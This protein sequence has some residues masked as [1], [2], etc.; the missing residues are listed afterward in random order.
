MWTWSSSKREVNGA[1][2][3]GDPLSPT[4]SPSHHDHRPDDTTRGRRLVEQWRCVLRDSAGAGV[5]IAWSDFG[6]DAARQALAQQV[7]D[8]HSERSGERGGRGDSGD[9][10]TFLAG[11]VLVKIEKLPAG[12]KSG[13]MS[14]AL[15]ALPFDVAALS[16]LKVLRF[17]GDGLLSDAVL[18]A[19]LKCSTL[20]EV[21][22]PG[23]KVTTGRLMDLL[24]AAE[25]L[26]AGANPI[27]GVPASQLCLAVLSA[28]RLR[29]NAIETVPPEVLAQLPALTEL[30]LSENKLSEAPRLLFEHCPALEM[31]NLERNPGLSVR[32]LDF[33]ACQLKSLLLGLSGPAASG[34]CPNLAAISSLTNLSIFSLHIQ[35]QAER[36]YPKC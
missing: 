28:L 33:R 19:L 8:L 6:L 34:Y 26:Q 27:E 21:D 16:S 1:S 10:D 35:A 32:G 29:K 25:G 7:R 36:R 11:V 22:L 12:E 3:P 18:S 4:G 15:E 2:A 17:A 5:H 24:P 31:L 9:V 13:S 20:R 30:D 23:Q 14:A